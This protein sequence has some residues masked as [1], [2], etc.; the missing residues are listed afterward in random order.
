MRSRDSKCA[1][2][3]VKGK[4]GTAEW[5]WEMGRGMTKPLGKKC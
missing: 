5:L 1:S 4:K 3:A 2:L